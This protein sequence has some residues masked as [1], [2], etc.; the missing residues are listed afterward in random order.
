MS[1]TTATPLTDCDDGTLVRLSL[2]TRP[3]AFDVLVKRYLKPVYTVV[4]HTVQDPDLA[5]DLTQ[6]TF[7]RV[8][9]SLS[10][11]DT[12][13]PF[14]PWLFTIAVNLA[15]TALRQ[16]KTRPVLLSESG[17]E[18]NLLENQAD[19]QSMEGPSVSDD[20]LKAAVDKAL[21]SLPESTR[22]AMILR[23]LHDLSYEEVAT[24]LNA[25]IN[26]VRTW[27]R[28]GREALKAQ[29]ELL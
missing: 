2:T 22:Q 9:R 26:T 16:A 7:L 10:R 6:E 14:K 11:F 15:K 1:V 28:R 12:S 29:L 24:S 25:N 17:Q 20:G 21:A 3:E 13:R 23:H 19:P 4:A 5:E 8:F 18:M 27:L